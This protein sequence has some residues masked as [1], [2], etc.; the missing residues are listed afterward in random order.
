MYLK[1]FHQYQRVNITYDHYDYRKTNLCDFC[2]FSF[3]IYG[4][5]EE[6]LDKQPALFNRLLHVDHLIPSEWKNV[7]QEVERLVEQQDKVIDTMKVN[8]WL[9]F[10]CMFYTVHHELFWYLLCRNSGKTCK[11]FVHFSTITTND[12]RP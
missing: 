4:R 1:A 12:N 7:K 5:K 10:D 2:D 11:S 8:V 3:T 6:L 9:G